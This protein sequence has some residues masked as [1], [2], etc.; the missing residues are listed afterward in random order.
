MRE[1]KRP[2]LY[3]PNV[4]TPQPEPLQLHFSP[5]CKVKCMHTQSFIHLHLLR[6]R[7]VIPFEKN[8]CKKNER[9][10]QCHFHNRVL[11]FWS[12]LFLKR[13]KM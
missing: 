2:R 7:N 12:D 10:L 6:R 5:C 3:Q 4:M 9:P 13:K 11:L 8:R 1:E